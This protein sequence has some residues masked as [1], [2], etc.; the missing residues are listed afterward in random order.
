MARLL[1]ALT[2]ILLVSPKV[3]FA[4]NIDWN[5]IENS[6]QNKIKGQ[7]VLSKNWMVSAA[8]PYAVKAGAEILS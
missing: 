1:I 5:K 8:N 4:E 7:P 3:I 2:L 6:I